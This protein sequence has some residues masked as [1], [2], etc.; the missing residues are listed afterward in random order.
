MKIVIIGGNGLI[1]SKAGKKLREG[2]HQVVSASPSTGVNT[3][4]GAGLTTALEGAHVVVDVSNSPS[5][6]DAAVM[7]FF[8]ISTGNLLREEAAASVGHHVAVS[9]VGADRLPDSGYMRAKRVQE[10]LIRDSKIPY[11][12]LRATQFFEF[13]GAI[14]ESGADGQTVRLTGARL[15]PVAA[16]DVASEVARIAV[17]PPLNGMVELAGP[18]AAPLAE[19]CR[20]WLEA[21]EDSR[22]LIIDNNA[23]YFGELLDD[24]SLV[25]EHSSRIGSIRFK[26]WLSRIS[27]HT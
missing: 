5:F 12:I 22:K 18:D 26:D 20:Q 24:R 19:F 14:A 1:G 11:T 9:V 10:D 21:K 6:E 8:R 2:G 23:R 17:D 3:I 15:Q 4:T 7:D 27:V 13:I 25:P 16:E